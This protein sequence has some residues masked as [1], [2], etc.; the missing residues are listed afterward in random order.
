M[1]NHRF[2]PY[3]IVSCIIVFC[4]VCYVGYRSYQNYV[5]FKDFTSKIKERQR[6]FVK[7]TPPT[8]GGAEK[9]SFSNQEVDANITA[10]PVKVRWRT[11]EIVRSPPPK[12]RRGPRVMH[13]PE[14]TV[15]KRVQTPDGKIHTIYWPR[16]ME[17]PEGIS[18]T[19]AAIKHLS[20]PP[21]P[22]PPRK[23]Y[24]REVVVRNADIPEG[25]DV[26]TYI[27][28]LRI[29]SDYGVSIEE[30]EQMLA[31]G[32]IRIEVVERTPVEEF[33]FDEF[34]GETR[35]D[36]APIPSQRGEADTV[37]AGGN[38]E[39]ISS[40]STHSPEPKNLVNKAHV[41]H[42]DGHVHSLPA[43]ESVETELRKPLL[44][45]RFDKVQQ[46][47]DQ[48]GSEEGLRRFREMDPEAARQFESD[49]SKPGREHR[50]M[51]DREVP[52][53]AGTSTQ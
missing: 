16:H 29:A 34:F 48:Y 11:Q 41:H 52:G 23:R 36:T 42:E 9:S 13:T 17:L 22:P 14:N 25:E 24:T 46:L 50:P 8:G 51:P 21:V 40:P 30:A 2:T 32:Q 10:S 31:S 19:P 38:F 28:K 18:F 43:A 35:L 4:L 12:H 26:E 33:T 7:D 53:E 39:A 44:P 6:S 1:F 49:K 3:I 37:S 45:E 15:K 20:R 5:E 47:I 27:D